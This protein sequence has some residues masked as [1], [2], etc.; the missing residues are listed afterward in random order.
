MNIHTINQR[1]RGYLQLLVIAGLA[2]IALFGFIAG[3][4][5]LALIIGVLISIHW[6][7][8]NL[9]KTRHHQTY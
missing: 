8:F 7:A 3:T 1:L 4:V 2:L 5:S 9:R 6:L